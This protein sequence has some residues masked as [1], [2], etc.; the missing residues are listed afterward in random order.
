MAGFAAQAAL[1]SKWGDL[2]DSGTSSLPEPSEAITGLKNVVGWLKQVSSI[3]LINYP[4][5]HLCLLG[6]LFVCKLIF[7]CF[8]PLKGPVFVICLLL[9]FL[10]S[11]SD[12]IILIRALCLN[13]TGLD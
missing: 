7:V 1:R 3:H 12:R 10:L 11:P 2:V 13:L 4:I 9:F 5:R 6:S 8:A